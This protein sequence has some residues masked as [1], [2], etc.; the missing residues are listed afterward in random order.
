MA[1]IHVEIVFFVSHRWKTA[2]EGVCRRASASW[3]AC[4]PTGRFLPARMHRCTDTRRAPRPAAICSTRI[5]DAGAGAPGSR[6]PARRRW[7]RLRQSASTEASACV[8]A[9]PANAAQRDP[10]RAIPTRVSYQTS[11]RPGRTSAKTR[12]PRRT[13][14]CA[15]HRRPRGPR[16]DGGGGLRARGG[17]SE[18]SWRN[19]ITACLFATT[20]VG[21]CDEECA[22]MSNGNGLDRTPMKPRLYIGNLNFRPGHLRA[23]LYACWAGVDFEEVL[24]DLN[25]P[26]Y[27]ERARSAKCWPFRLRAGARTG[28]R[29]RDRLGHVGHRTMGDL[30]WRAGF[31]AA[32]GCQCRNRLW[33]GGRNAFRLR[34]GAA[35][36]VDEHSPPLH[37]ARPA[38]FGTRADIARMDALW[39]DCRERFG[40]KPVASCWANA[41]S[42][43]RFSCRGYALSYLAFRCPQWRSVYDTLRCKPPRMGSAM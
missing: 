15:T 1:F 18:A 13:R 20:V 17:E 12:P 16:G 2:L 24:I 40:P 38:C 31:V 4:R 35:R 23:W 32:K 42:P 41:A 11:S 6:Q 3:R 28:H 25:Q 43:M 7:C 5:N 36:P 27:G 39:S 30:Q 29:Q 22:R 37:G 14:R 19:I 26:G 8:G 9:P 10:H 34:C 21:R 33:S